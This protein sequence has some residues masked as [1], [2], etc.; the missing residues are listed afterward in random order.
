[1]VKSSSF[2]QKP[3]NSPFKKFDFLDVFETS[4]H[5]SKKYP[6]LSRILENDLFCLLCLKNQHGNK[7]EF[8]IKT[9]T[10]PFERL[11]FSDDFETSLFWSK[12]YSFLSIILKSNLFLL[13]LEKAH[14]VKS[15]IFWQE[16]WTKPF[17][18][19]RFFT[20]FLKSSFFC[21]KKYSFL[22]RILNK[23]SFLP[24]FA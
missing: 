12:E 9:R 5:C 23:Q 4:L 17:K 11:D 14:M 1:M 16:S 13:G 19:L 8:L 22:S 2:W 20:P 6:F 7:L 18:N 10:Y 24:W 3:W 15:S 21:F